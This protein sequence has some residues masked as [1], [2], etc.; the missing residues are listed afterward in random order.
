M[1]AALLVSV[2]ALAPAT[3]SERSTR[4][5]VEVP[6]VSVFPT[7]VLATLVSEWVITGDGPAADNDGYTE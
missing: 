1:L 3:A 6:R 2:L 5:W 4:A 7:L